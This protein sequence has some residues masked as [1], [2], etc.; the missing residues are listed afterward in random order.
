VNAIICG[1]SL[2]G[3][4]AFLAALATRAER[5]LTG[6]SSFL[7]SF[8]PAA[9]LAASVA[10]ARPEEALARGAV[11]VA[12]AVGAVADARTGYIFDCI[13]LPA[14]AAG[15][16]IAQ[17]A[18]DV[19]SAVGALAIV[20]PFALFAAASWIGWGDVKAIFSLAIAFGPFESS[21]A[22]FVACLCGIVYARARGRRSCPSRIPFVP[23]LATGAFVAFIIARPLR[24]FIGG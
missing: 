16:V 14:A 7:V 22:L 20:L 19:D 3:W 18:H 12:L 4:A 15:I 5:S 9:A 6:K 2:V 11:L 8:A 10:V 1:A 21:L 13:T 17:V 24:I 23:P